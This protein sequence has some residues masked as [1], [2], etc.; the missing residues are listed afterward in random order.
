MLSGPSSLASVVY[1]IGE[2]L[3]LDYGIDPKPTFRDL[4]IPEDGPAG[5]FDRIPNSVVGEMWSRAE[6]LSKDPAFGIR[7]G[8]NVR[9]LPFDM[10]AHAWLASDTLVDALRCMIRYEDMSNSGITDI[11]CEKSGADYIISES[12]P[13]AADYPG[14][15]AVDSSISGII[16]LSRIARG[17]PIYATRL[18]VYVPKDAPLDIY[19]DLVRGPVVRSDERNA[20]FLSADDLEAPLSGA[21]PEIVDAVSQTAERYLRSFDT[22]KVSYRVR[23]LIIRMLPSGPVD[24]E[25]IARKLFRSVSTLQRQLG[26]EGTSYREILG[27]AREQM[28]KGYMQEHRYSQTQIAFMLGYSDQ[29]N[30]SRAFKRRTGQ[31]PGEFRNANQDALTSRLDA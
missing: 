18:E 31:S 2:T 6:E 3:K 12:Y 11:R 20:L 19:S 23:E 15:L 13:N 17:K 9:K 25:T 24:Q 22:S 26:T 21:V 5:R 28:A 14:K 16:H 29:S 30:F 4:G 8:A 1:V 7:A 27:D 10:F